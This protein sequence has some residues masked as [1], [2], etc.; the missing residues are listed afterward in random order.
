MSLSPDRFE[1]MKPQTP[2]DV[3]GN[4]RTYIIN[5]I[6]AVDSR[7]I[8][9]QNKRF[10]LGFGINGQPCKNLLEALGFTYRVRW[11]TAEQMSS[12]HC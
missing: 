11:I 3:L 6:D 12:C 8:V 10:T 9:L 2:I 4:L 5:A 1:G 7:S